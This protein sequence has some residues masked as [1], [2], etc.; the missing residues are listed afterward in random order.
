MTRSLDNKLPG[1]K[2]WEFNLYVKDHRIHIGMSE[3]HLEVKMWIW[4]VDMS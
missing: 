4:D 1:D 2:I 3:F